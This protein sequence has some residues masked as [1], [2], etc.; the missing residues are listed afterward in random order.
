M[1][2][3]DLGMNGMEIRRQRNRLRLSRSKLAERLGVSQQLVY[4]WERGER[5]ISQSHREA[6]K[7]LSRQLTIERDSRVSL[8]KPC[9]A[10]VRSIH[11]HLVNGQ[12]SMA[13]ELGE[14][15]LQ[16]MRE[17]DADWVRV[18]H[19]TAIAY[20]LADSSA[21]R[22]R[23][24]TMAAFK[25]LNDSQHPK[26]LRHAITNEILGYRLKE[27][28][29]SDVYECQEVFQEVRA[30]YDEDQKLSYLWN[31]LEVLCKCSAL[32]GKIPELLESLY[33]AARRSEVNE[34]IDADPKYSAA[35]QHCDW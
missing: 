19:F 33:K 5:T 11:E 25:A 30:L 2:R 32:H 12:D 18:A 8:E 35:K 21:P 27:L 31:S 28:D 1:S 6:F 26:W 29:P 3:N 9:P 14:Y 15:C 4:Y 17:N 20:S 7:R 13:Q 24:L 34:R 23:E 10:V 16:H 22:G